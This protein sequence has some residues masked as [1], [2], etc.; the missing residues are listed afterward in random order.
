GDARALSFESGSVWLIC[1][2]GAGEIADFLHLSNAGMLSAIHVKAAHSRSADR[3][4]AVT[5]FEQVVS[6]ALKNVR[7]LNSDH[8]AHR[9]SRP[10]ISR[11]ACWRDGQRVRDRTEFIL[12]LGARGAADRTS[13]IIVQQHLSQAVHDR[14][15]AATWD[16]RPNRDSHSLMLLDNLLHSAR[17][18]VIGLWDDLTVIGSK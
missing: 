7:L 16:G 18:T 1:D 13:V 9:L 8:L 5:A 3:Q 12:M 11:P 10:R 15:R 6:Q 2:D 17:R 4:I 14:A